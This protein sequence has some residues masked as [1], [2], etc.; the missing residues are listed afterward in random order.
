MNENIVTRPVW[1]KHIKGRAIIWY[2]RECSAYDLAKRITGENVTESEYRAALALLDR[3]QRYG[4]ARCPP[5][6]NALT[7]PNAIA[8]VP[9]ASRT[10]AT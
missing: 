10:K 7:I 5:N 8:I 2:R 1:S 9:S 3:I 6:G 4:L